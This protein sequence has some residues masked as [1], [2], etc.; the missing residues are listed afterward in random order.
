MSLNLEESFKEEDNTFSENEL[1]T[2]RRLVYT[3]FHQIKDNLILPLDKS[4]HK[5]HIR[6]LEN[7]IKKISNIL[8]D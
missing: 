8:N 7:I 4:Y 6:K 2:I 3:E 5:N 1:I